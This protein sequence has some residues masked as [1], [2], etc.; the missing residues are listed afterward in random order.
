[1]AFSTSAGGPVIPATSSPM[2]CPPTYSM[3]PWRMLSR[4]SKRR[5]ASEMMGSS[6]R[7]P[8][9]GDLHDPS[10][11]AV[12][13]PLRELERLRPRHQLAGELV[14]GRREDPVDRALLDHR[15]AVHHR[16][17]VA[18]GLHD[19]H[20]VG[21]HHERDPPLAVDVPQQVEDRRGGL[22]VERRG[23]L[24][25]EQDGRVVGQRPGDAHPLLLA[26]GEL[27]R[28]GVAVPR[29]ARPARGARAPAARSPRRG[30]PPP[31]ARRP[32][33]RRRSGRASG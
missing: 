13:E 24:V 30:A 26:A 23:G 19:L 18:D 12:E 2:A 10:V 15:P 11:G 32:R 5:D 8:A 14:A 21:D 31:G 4:T 7:S 16:H 33:S 6:A 29:P 3:R 20:L 27:R 22:Q 28:V 1:M 9:V 25:A 17:P